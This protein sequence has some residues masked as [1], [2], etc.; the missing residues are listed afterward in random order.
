MARARGRRRFS[1]RRS[2]ARRTRWVENTFGL[3]VTL[4]SDPTT[5]NQ[6]ASFW[7]KWPASLAPLSHVVAPNEEFVITNEPV[8]ETLV[9]TLTWVNGLALTPG[10]AGSVTNPPNLTYG[11]IAFDG[12]E[13]PDFYDFAI[14]DSNASFVAPPNPTRQGDDP[15]VITNS[16]FLVN[17]SLFFENQGND[18]HN[19]T[20]AAKRKLPAGTGLLFVVGVTNVF[21]DGEST[22]VTLNIGGCIRMAA[23]SGFSV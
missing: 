22:P 5:G 3:A 16:L 11:I 23:R 17:E 7:A 8:D 9:K 15:W 4:E 10:A 20:S 2:S 21:S 13:Y 1:S 12:G 18:L 14:F 6:W 19:R